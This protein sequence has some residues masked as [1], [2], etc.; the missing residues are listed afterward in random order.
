MRCVWLAIQTARPKSTS[1]SEPD[2]A[3]MKNESAK[4]RRALA[5]TFRLRFCRCRGLY[6]INPCCGAPKRRVFND[7]LT[8]EAAMDIGIIE[9][10]QIEGNAKPMVLAGGN[11]FIAETLPTAGDALAQRPSLPQLLG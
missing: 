4:P 2:D 8:I 11:R 7:I 10:F 5:G 6:Q 9:R 3:R 1:A